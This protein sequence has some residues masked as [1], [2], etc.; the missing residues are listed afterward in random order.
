MRKS[1]KINVYNITL[2]DGTKE[3]VEVKGR[4]DYAETIKKGKIKWIDYVSTYYWNE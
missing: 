4:L 2:V 1:I 3:R